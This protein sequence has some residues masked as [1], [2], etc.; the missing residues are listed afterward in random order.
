MN[1]FLISNDPSLSL[2]KINQIAINPQDIVCLFNHANPIK[3]NKILEHKQKYLFLRYHNNSYWGLDQAIKYQKFYDKIIFINH[4]KESLEQ[5][6]NILNTTIFIN[7]SEYSTNTYP[8]NKYPTSG[9]VAYNYVL[10]I[11]NNIFLVNFT[12]HG[13]RCEGWNKHD[14]IFEQ[15]YYKAKSVV[16]I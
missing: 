12:G 11:C 15:Q 8:N 5:A 6:K 9:F 13:S 16:I 4:N 7:E 2:A 10:Q 1:I 14:Y 3:F